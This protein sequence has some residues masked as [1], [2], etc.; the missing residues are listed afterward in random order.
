MVLLLTRGRLLLVL[1]VLPLVLL[2]AA[3]LTFGAAGWCC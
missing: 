1:L 3:E 2:I